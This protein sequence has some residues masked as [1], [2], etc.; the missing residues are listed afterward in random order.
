[1]LSGNALAIS[2]KNLQLG[3]NCDN[4]HASGAGMDVDT[5]DWHKEN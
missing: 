1:M 2:A 5:K 3:M 4:G